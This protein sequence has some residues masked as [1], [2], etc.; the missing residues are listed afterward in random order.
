[1]YIE[2]NLFGFFIVGRESLEVSL[3][4]FEKWQ[5]LCIIGQRADYAAAIPR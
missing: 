5:C 3:S 1:M 4:C 2:P